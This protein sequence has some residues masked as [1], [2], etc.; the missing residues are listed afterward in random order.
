M[1]RDKSL[2]LGV[3][4]DGKLDMSQQC[5]PTAQKANRILGCIKKSV[6]SRTREVIL[7][8][9]STVEISPEVLQ[10]DKEFSEQE[11]HRPVEAHPEGHQ[12]DPR[13]ETPPLSGK[14]ERAG[15]VQ[16]GKEIAPGRTGNNLHVSN[17][18]L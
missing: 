9:H 8:L 14:A 1:K 18:E 15:A 3:L 11:R 17:G 5:D 12:H 13:Y 6:V 4:V 10:P 7:P 2:N 16:P